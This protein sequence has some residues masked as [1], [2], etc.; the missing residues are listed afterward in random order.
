MLFSLFS[1]IVGSL[2]DLL[3]LA[4]LARFAM[5]WARVPFRN[6]LGRF[7]AAATDWAVLPV[8]RLVPGLFG[9]DLASLLLAW[10][11]QALFVSIVVG[12]SGLHGGTTA[13]AFGVAVVVSL[14]ETLRLAV[15]LAMGVVI[16]AALLSW[17][18][19][20]A[21]LAPVINQM[22]R[23][24]LGPVQRRLPPLGG[25]DLSPVV[26]L[27]A[28]QALLVVLGYARAA[29]LPGLAP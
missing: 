9:F 14:I 16:V 18:N 24:L 20:Y 11:V 26:V 7:V 10:L 4:F 12:A 3:A 29:L 6:P 27:L 28:L 23:P 8:R 5:Q 19:P 25:I 22:A 17:L 1:L 13:A 21:P 15:Y 2:C